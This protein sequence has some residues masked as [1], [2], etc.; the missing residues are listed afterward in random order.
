MAGKGQST[1]DV[2]CP[3]AGGQTINQTGQLSAVINPAIQPC[4]MGVQMLCNRGRKGDQ[5][6][7]KAGIDVIQLSIEQPPQVICVSAGLCCGNGD[8]CDLTIGA[9]DRERH[10]PR[11]EP[12][13]MKA[14]TKFFA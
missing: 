3:Q 13:S 12:F 9:V 2:M 5:I 10:T 1:A 14:F 8:I 11:A 4:L 6:E 7:P